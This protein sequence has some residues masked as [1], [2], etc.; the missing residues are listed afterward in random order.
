MIMTVKDGR[1]NNNSDA[2]TSLLR[3]DVGF[4]QKLSFQ[5]FLVQ[6]TRFANVVLPKFPTTAVYSQVRALPDCL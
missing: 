6:S 1:R 2:P 3:V 5:N 4:W